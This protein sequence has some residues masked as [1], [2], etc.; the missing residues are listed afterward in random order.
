M[1]NGAVKRLVGMCADDR[2]A[3]VVFHAGLPRAGLANRSLRPAAGPSPPSHHTVPSLAST[4][5]RVDRVA[6]DG[7]RSCWGCSWQLVPG[8]TP[9]KPVSGLMAHSRPSAVDPHPRDVVADGPDA[10]ALDPQ[11]LG[12]DHHRQ[13]RLAAGAGEGGGDV[14]D[15]ARRDSRRPGS[16]CARPSSPLAG[17]G[18]WRCAGR[19]TS[20]PAARCRR[21][22]SR[23]SRWRC[24]RGSAGSAGGWMSRSA[25]PCRHRVNSPSAPSCSSTGAPTWVMIRMFSTT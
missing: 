10:V 22:P 18:S 12:R 25:L 9:K 1:V 3:L 20:C 5:V 2:L 19:G 14:L 4:H 11:A 23:R 6:A 13:V 16:A 24:P 21:S 8:A 15:A 7:R 17:P